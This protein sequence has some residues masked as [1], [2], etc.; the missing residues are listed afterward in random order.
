MFQK[1]FKS[2]LPMLKF[3]FLFFLNLVITGFFSKE[4]VEN[5]NTTKLIPEFILLVIFITI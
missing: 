2:T 1:L 5:I 3:L 4:T